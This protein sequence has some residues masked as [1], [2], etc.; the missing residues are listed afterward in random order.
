M[1]ILAKQKGPGIAKTLSKMKP[2]LHDQFPEGVKAKVILQNDLQKISTKI[3]EDLPNQ[4][5]L[6][7]DKNSF[8]LEFESTKEVKEWI[9]QFGET[10]EK[11]ERSFPSFKT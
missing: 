11:Q 1:V 4:F 8:L 5:I 10:K 3:V 9:S 6:K 7:T 2:K